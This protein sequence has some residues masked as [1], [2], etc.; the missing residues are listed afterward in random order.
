MNHGKQ[1]PYLYCIQK[2]LPYTRKNLYYLNRIPFLAVFV[3]PEN[4][5]SGIRYENL[6]GSITYSFL[7]NPTACNRKGETLS[8]SVTPREK[9]CTYY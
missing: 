3:T 2:Q 6:I 5:E 7:I 9:N 4:Q 1:L 8:S